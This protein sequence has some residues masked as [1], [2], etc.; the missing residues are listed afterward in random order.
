MFF[1]PT[2]SVL[3]TTNSSNINKVITISAVFMLVSPV[4]GKETSWVLPHNGNILFPRQGKVTDEDGNT[5]PEKTILFYVHLL[6]SSLPSPH[7]LREFYSCNT[8]LATCRISLFFIYPYVPIL[9]PSEPHSGRIAT[10]HS[11]HGEM[12]TMLNGEPALR[13]GK[14][15]RRCCSSR[16]SLVNPK[17]FRLHHPM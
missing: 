10:Y 3:R 4:Q 14:R 5:R 2:Y 7:Q 8:T 1:W 13:S 9:G 12:I 16:S 11:R 17:I 15:T 6:G